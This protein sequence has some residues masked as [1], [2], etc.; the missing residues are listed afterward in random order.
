MKSD[1]CERGAQGPRK[2]AT[3]AHVLLTTGTSTAVT[4]EH[5]ADVRDT[6]VVSLSSASSMCGSMLV[7]WCVWRP[8]LLHPH[9]LPAVAFYF[10]RAS[11]LCGFVLRAYRSGCNHNNRL[12]ISD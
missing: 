1:E 6:A 3:D 2:R 12:V 10:E 9:D 4:V 5:T 7:G 8:L 11:F